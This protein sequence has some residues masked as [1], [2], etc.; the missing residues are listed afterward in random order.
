MTQ[1]GIRHHDPKLKTGKKV[2]LLRPMSIPLAVLLVVIFT[3]VT[4][5][6]LSGHS[7]RETK[8][9]ARNPTL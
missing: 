3:D 1:Q 5:L 7:P 6:M 8:R 4:A 2:R 9:F